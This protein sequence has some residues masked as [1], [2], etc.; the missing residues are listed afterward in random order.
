[1]NVVLFDDVELKKTTG[2]TSEIIEENNYYAF[3]MKHEGYNNITTATDPALKYKYNGKELQD[4]MGL[5]MYDYGARFY[6]PSTGRWYSVDAMAEKYHEMSPYTYAADNPLIYIDPDGN[7]I[8][9]CCQTLKDVMSGVYSTLR[10]EVKGTY[11]FVTSDA[12]K[13]STWKALGNTALAGIVAPGVPYSSKQK[14]LSK[15]DNSLGTNTV[16]INQALKDSFDEGKDQLFNGNAEERASVITGMAL[17][18]APS[19]IDD[20]GKLSKLTNAIT[21]INKKFSTGAL[22]DVGGLEAVISSASYYEKVSDQGAHIFNSIAGGH[23][24]MDGNKRT[25]SA[26]IQQYAKYNGLK[27]KVDADGL[28]SLTSELAK[29]KKY[30]TTELSKKLFE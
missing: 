29:G 25:A 2:V 23:V 21:D 6:E 20:L 18:F 10:A 17:L 5:D 22:K 9:M 1:M 15:V 30:N 3:G 24:F 28:Q 11:D 8:S 4:E 13:G 19:K 7:E 12:W 16:G 14:I 27:L 26:F